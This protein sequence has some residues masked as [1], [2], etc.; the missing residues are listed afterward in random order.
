MWMEE[1]HRYMAG[2]VVD[3]PL[4][5]GRRRVAVQEA[6]LQR[7]RMNREADAAL[8]R[9]QTEVAQARTRVVEARRVQQLYATRLV[10][11]AS[12]RITTAR[13]ALESGGGSFLSLINAEN[14]LRD[15]ELKQHV[16][17]ADVRRRL[18]ELE[19]A[20]GRLPGADSEE[21]P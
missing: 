19:R 20:V 4:Q 17:A 16:A 7:T 12:D 2:V 8:L 15:V 9:V 10:P 5:L 21:S 13:A 6:S 1:P 11:T 18:A 14:A 3:V